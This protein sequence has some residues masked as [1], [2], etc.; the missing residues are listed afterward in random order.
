M[1]ALLLA[2]SLALLV[3]ACGAPSKLQTASGR[4]EVSIPG[5]TVD[6]VKAEIVRAMASG[7]YRIVRDSQYEIAFDRPAQ[8]PAAVLMGSRYDPVPMSRMSFSFAP[9]GSSVLVTGDASIVTN[10]GSGFEQRVDSNGGPDGTQLQ[11]ALNQLAASMDPA[12]P[13]SQARQRGLIMG[14]SFSSVALAKSSGLQVPA[15]VTTG[16]YLRGVTPNM[17]GAKAGL[18]KGDVMIA[19]AGKPVTD[20]A[21]LEAAI[22]TL[23]PGARTQATVVRPSGEETVSIQFDKPR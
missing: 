5:T 21:S 1:R 22:A 11:E 14:V 16:L 4:P 15:G 7:G 2:I 17:P 6:A 3:G 12:S 13:R 23:Q 20:D 10:P 9:M 19:F 18:Q 8:G